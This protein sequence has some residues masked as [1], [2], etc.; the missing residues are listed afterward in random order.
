MVSSAYLRLLIFFLAILIL[1]CDFL[2]FTWYTLHIHHVVLEK[3]PE[4][5]TDCKEI[6]PENQFWIFIGR[7]DA[8]AEASTL[9]PPDVKNWLIGKDPDAGK[10]WRWK[11]GTTENEVVRWHHQHDGPEFEQALGVGD[12]QGGL[13]CCSPWD[14]KDLDTTE[15]LNWTELCI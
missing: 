13:V 3:T 2:H 9:W 6:K 7:T 8:E 4:S 15:Q 1:A 5:P 10:D 12:V 11:K 14:G